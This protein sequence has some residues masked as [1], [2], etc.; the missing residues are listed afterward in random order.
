MQWNILPDWRRHA[1]SFTFILVAIAFSG[2]GCSKTVPVRDAFPSPLIEALPLDVG[3]FYDQE[4]LDFSHENNA[5]SSK[6]IV[7]FGSAHTELF[8]QLFKTLFRHVVLVEEI[9]SPTSE[10]EDVDAIIAPSIEDIAFAT[11]D[12]SGLDFYEVSLRYRVAL[13]RP[14]GELINAWSIN[15]YGR[16]PSRHFNSSQSVSEATTIA[17][18]D[19]AAQLA[20]GFQARPE[21]KDLLGQKLNG[22]RTT[23]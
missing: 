11:P 18:R 2:F 23:Q 10:S 22:Y 15:G 3:L 4:L 17:M 13:Y 20:I 14:S 9:P 5:S 16:S 21:V 1:V 19:A 7:E 8:D 12:F 6:W